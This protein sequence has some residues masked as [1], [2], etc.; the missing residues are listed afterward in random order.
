MR[1][2]RTLLFITTIVLVAISSSVHSRASRPSVDRPPVAKK[3]HA[4]FQ[5]GA[6]QVKAGEPAELRFDILNDAGESVRF[7]QYVHERP[8]HL[9]IVS[10]DLQ[11]FY[12]VHPELVTDYF[13]LSQTFPHGG[14]YHLFADFTPPGG[15]QTV[16]HFTLDVAGQKRPN[17]PLIPDDTR[18]KTLDG[19][20]VTMSADKPL[21]AGE[22]MLSTFSLA[23]ANTGNPVND[24]QLYLG[25][26]AHVAIF[27][28]TL[29]SLIH[30]HPLDAG[31]IYDPSNGPQYHTHNPED[32]AKKLVGPSPS[33]V[34]VPMIVPHAG[35]YKMWVQFQRNGHVIAVPFVVAVHEAASKTETQT[36]I[37]ADAVLVKIS[38]SG[39]EPS[40]I[41]AAAGKS[42]KLA[43]RRIDAQNCGGTV[44]FPELNISRTLAVGETSI[45]EFT[46]ERSGSFS[47]ACAMGMYK[48]VVVVTN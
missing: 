32:V 42:L 26:L 35:L 13:S 30:A 8:I 1:I 25:A 17:V 48:G 46:P 36:E 18:T 4:K 45:I 11:E 21:R 12:H 20:R 41:E 27:D 16:E 22:D 6:G 3:F 23:D 40:R 43:F 14:K 24:L 10:D 37:P 19:L 31:E 34:R 28:Q 5:V 29:T 44:V 47:F 2:G 15:Y 39:Y 9:M 7:L 38:S 33:E